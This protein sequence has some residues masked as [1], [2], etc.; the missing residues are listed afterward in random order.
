MKNE[1][2]SLLLTIVTAVSCSHPKNNVAEHVP[3]ERIDAVITDWTP[4]SVFPDSLV[5]G[6]DLYRQAIGMPS[7]SLD[8]AIAVVHESR[9]TETFGRDTRLRFLSTTEVETALGEMLGRLKT[10]IPQVKVDRIYGV[11]SPYRQSIIVADSS[12]LIA[13][14][15]YLGSDYEGYQMLSPEMRERKVPRQIAPDVAE[16][17]VRVAMPYRPRE[18][19]VLE[20]LLYEGAVSLAVDEALDGKEATSRDI[21]A[22]CWK[23][24]AGDGVLYSTSEMVHGRVFDDR[25]PQSR[26]LGRAIIDSY[27]QGDDTLSVATMLSPEFYNDAQKRL[28]ESRFQP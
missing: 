8:S 2:L 16:A 22:S 20:R 13:L 9:V 12:V 14:N 15:H 11:V 10:L 23:E 26:A 4:G 18:N 28:I 17:L 27:R 25:H 1:F 24:L 6:F 7:M 3:L 19:S 5:D 21:I